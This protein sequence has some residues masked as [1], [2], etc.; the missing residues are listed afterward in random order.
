MA[1]LPAESV[2]QQALK[3]GLLTEPQFQECWENMDLKSASAETLLRFLERKVYLTPWQ[4]QKLLKGET[5]GYF[6]GGY[7]LLYKIAS[8][9]FGRVFRADD[10]HTGTVVAIKVLRRRFSEE[11]RTITLFEREGQVGRS[12]RH[13]NI[14]SI[15]AV[16]RDVPSQQYYLVMEFVEGGNL[17]DFL[18]IRKK[19][20]PFEALRLLED[21]ASGLAYAFSVGVTH[22][23]LKPTNILISAQGAAKLVDFGL[24]GMFGAE[25]DGKQGKM[26]RTVDYAG[27]EKATSVKPG[28]PRSDIYFLGCV[29]FEMLTGKSPLDRPADPNARMKKTR[30]DQALTA[31]PEDIAGPRSVL[32]LLQ[33][34][35]AYNPQER[36]QTPAQLLDAIREVRAEVDGAA[37]STA[38][39]T[40]ERSVFVVEKNARLQ[41]ALRDRFKKMGY[42]VFLAGEPYIALNRFRLK[43]Y[44]ALVLDAGEGNEESVETFEK[45]MTEAGRQNYLCGG[46]LILSEN[47]A[48]WQEKV[49]PRSN[50]AILVRPV[51]LKQVSEQLER[52]VPLNNRS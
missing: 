44:D 37:N 36:Y 25:E 6:L 31:Q 17:R 13:P 30:F 29:F 19:L 5:D 12:L 22:R 14:V 41:D 24:A 32:H 49:Q 4:S 16:D 27:L 15:L 40:V 39:R 46:I 45:I 42:R 21:A 28:D 11:K 43:P 3:L 34:M 26:Y 52:F 47:Q 23:D 10:P 51:N 48:P 7:R 20:Q 38:N 9:S 35:M 50:V 18:A 1:N 33:K 2:A 8:G